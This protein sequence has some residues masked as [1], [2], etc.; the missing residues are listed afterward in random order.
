MK[1]MVSRF[2]Y[3]NSRLED[4]PGRGRPSDFDDQALLAAIKG[5]EILI[6]LMLIDNFKVYRS[7]IVRR[8]KKLGKV[9]KLTGWVPT[10]SATTIKANASEC[11][12]ICFNETSRL[13][14]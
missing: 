13:C 4:K 3:G 11:L 6:T 7:A 1:G 12:P 2:K 14:F 5:D 10:N 8:L 9:S